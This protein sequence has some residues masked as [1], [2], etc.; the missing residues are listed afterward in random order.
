MHA[1]LSFRNCPNHSWKTIT[2]NSL[3]RLREEVWIGW[4]ENSIYRY[5]DDDDESTPK[6]SNFSN[7][8]SL[9]FYCLHSHCV[10]VVV[11]ELPSFL[12]VFC[13][14]LF[15]CNKTIVIVA[16]W[17]TVGVWI[18]SCNWCHTT[19]L[20][21]KMSLTAEHCSTF[22]R[23]DFMFHFGFCLSFSFSICCNYI[24]CAYRKSHKKFE[25]TIFLCV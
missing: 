19:A 12:V 21:F 17:I 4:I 18:A 6:L 7:T 9:C 2:T 14:C 25:I 11:W 22:T 15:D 3:T 24:F 1:I 16:I 8:N 5:D 20:R 13:F 10:G 23:W